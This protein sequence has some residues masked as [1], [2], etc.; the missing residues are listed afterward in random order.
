MVY[1]VPDGGTGNTAIGVYD[2]PL[3]LKV[4]YR[5]SHGVGIFTGDE[6]LFCLLLCFGL[7]YVWGRVA[8]F[9]EGR[10]ARMAVLEGQTGAVEGHDGIVHSLDVWPYAALIAKTPEDDAR[11]IIV[12]LNK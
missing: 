2:I 11:V 5:I 8:E 6:R 9:V 10:I 1:P 7:E 3:L 4:A 12:T